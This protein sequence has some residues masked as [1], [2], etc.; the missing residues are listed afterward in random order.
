MRASKLTGAHTSSAGDAGPVPAAGRSGDTAGGRGASA[1]F[2]RRARP[3]VVVL[4]LVLIRTSS[5]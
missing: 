1:A 3:E 4:V 2:R 5:R